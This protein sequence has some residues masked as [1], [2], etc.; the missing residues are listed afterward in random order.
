MYYV[1]V[2]NIL[3]I[4]RALYIFYVRHVKGCE[5]F[6][7]SRAS[8]AWAR[9]VNKRVKSGFELEVEARE[10]RLIRVRARSDSFHFSPIVVAHYVYHI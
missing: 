10:A 4:K 5:L 2:K 6:D 1:G 7:P 9:L 3:L 8:Q